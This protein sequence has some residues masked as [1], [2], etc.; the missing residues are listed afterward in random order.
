MIYFGKDRQNATQMMAASVKRLTRRVEGAGHKLYMDN[1]YS[2]LDL[3][4]DLHIR[5]INCCQ[6]VRQNCKGMTLKKTQI[7]NG[8]KDVLTAMIWKD[9]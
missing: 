7:G 9:T 1:F 6:T 2:S 3:F 8:V 5:A 4:V